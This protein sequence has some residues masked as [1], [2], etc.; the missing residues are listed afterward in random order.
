LP[1]SFIIQG[2]FFL[3]IRAEA[4]CRLPRRLLS[5]QIRC[6]S[7]SKSFEKIT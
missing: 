6:A 7:R 4:R 5:L 2:G 1:I 3:W